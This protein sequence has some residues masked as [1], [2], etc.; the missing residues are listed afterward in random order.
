MFKV[1]SLARKS[2]EKKVDSRKHGEER[3]IQVL[4]AF[5]CPTGILVWLSQRGKVILTKEIQAVRVQKKFP[6]F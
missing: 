3:F 4:R 6:N 5:L 1:Q 2:Y